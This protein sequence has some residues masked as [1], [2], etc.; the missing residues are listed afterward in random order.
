MRGQLVVHQVSQVK[1]NQLHAAQCLQ[2]A[3]NL[4]LHDFKF[5]PRAGNPHEPLFGQLRRQLRFL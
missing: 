4:R 5:T 3:L 2:G 1:V